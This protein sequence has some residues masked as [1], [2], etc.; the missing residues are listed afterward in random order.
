MAVN[1]VYVCLCPCTYFICVC[2]HVLTC[3]R[4]F[5]LTQFGDKENLSKNT[6]L[7]IDMADMTQSHL[8]GAD[9]SCGPS[10]KGNLLTY[11]SV[12]VSLSVY[13]P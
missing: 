8:T 2:V 7:E 10:H 11:F 6:L 5:F 9:Q 4:N 1:T 13:L 12:C 3:S